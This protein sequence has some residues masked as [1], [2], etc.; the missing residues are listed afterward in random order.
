MSHLGLAYNAMVRGGLV[1]RFHT[2]NTIGEDTVAAHSY[3]VICLIYLLYEMQPPTEVL[4]S[5]MLHDTPEALVG[6][7]PSPTKKVIGGENMQALENT[8]L[9]SAGLVLP[10][11]TEAQ[12]RTLKLADNL[13]G[14]R[15]CIM[16]K[17]RGNKML[18]ECEQ[19]YRLYIERMRPF[20]PTESEVIWAV[21]NLEVT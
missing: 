6:D 9:H 11:L 18:A 10:E 5:A 14:L 20:T 2:L 21:K 17:N 12:A 8:F 19:N 15:F 13:D 7:M 4:V 3:G 16:E 1:K